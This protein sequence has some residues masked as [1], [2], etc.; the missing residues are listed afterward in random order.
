MPEIYHASVVEVLGVSCDNLRFLHQN[1]PCSNSFLDLPKLTCLF[2]WLR[3]RANIGVPKF[4][5][6]EVLT[7]RVYVFSFE[8]AIVSEPKCTHSWVVFGITVDVILVK[9]CEVFGYKGGRNVFLHVEVPS[10]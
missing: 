1:G 5:G 10:I 7:I 9:D 2:V 3:A 8:V 4:V 6:G